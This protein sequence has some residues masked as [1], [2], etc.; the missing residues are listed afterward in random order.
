MRLIVVTTLLA[1]GCKAEKE[2]VDR[3]P[4]DPHSA[5]DDTDSDTD[6][7]TDVGGPFECGTLVD[8]TAILGGAYYGGPSI[9]V[10]AD[11]SRYVAASFTG[12]AV[13]DPG[14][15]NETVLQ[16]AGYPDA[17][18]MH[19]ALDGTLDWV[20]HFER[21]SNLRIATTSDGVV[22][23]GSNNEN[24]YTISA[25][26]PDAVVGG[27]INMLG[28]FDP[29][30]R[31][32]WS[33]EYGG[34]AYAFMGSIE[35][36]P[37]DDLLIGGHYEMGPLEM[38]ADIVLP[39]PPGAVL[40]GYFARID[41]SNGEVLWAQAATG[42]LVAIVGAVRVEPGTSDVLVVGHGSGDGDIVLGAG[43][44]GEVS[45]TPVETASFFARYDQDGTL[46][47]AQ[48]M[49]ATR[50]MILAPA[51][52][53]GI[54]V[55]GR[56][57]SDIT[58]G[59]GALETELTTEQDDTFVARYESN[60]AFSWVQQVHSGT[61][62]NGVS[63]P[64]FYR[65][66]ATAEHGVLALGMSGMNARFGRDADLEL[67]LQGDFD[68]FIASYSPAGDLDCLVHIPASI[69]VL[70]YDAER[71]QD[72]TIW[73]AGSFHG[74]VMLG[75]DTPDEVTI[76]AVGTSQLMLPTYGF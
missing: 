4:T 64:Q 26:E 20:R 18:L 59:E 68:A 3:D 73:V 57:T 69:G 41:S 25:G 48:F 38:A 49:E 71:L 61:P 14:G 58:F 32:A 44:V 37:N 52:D 65:L 76:D 54:Y 60:G 50:D 47:W 16:A 12:T 30:G 8:D 28:R 2:R 23:G 67:N 56:F 66:I 75:R 45:T 62:I 5:A 36:F 7:D 72:D 31:L 42:P 24:S 11:G 13:L 10:A 35:V 43:Q 39:M 17:M 9:A 53:G 21:I 63:A 40:G 6:T 19:Y 74:S 33:T 22:F 46:E 55:G 70:L 15:P 51:D 29:D 34:G 27:G 1:L